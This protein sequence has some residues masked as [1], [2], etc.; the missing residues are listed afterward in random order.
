MIGSEWTKHKFGCSGE[1]RQSIILVP[2]KIPFIRKCVFLN[3]IIIFLQKVGGPW[4]LP[5]PP[6]ARALLIQ[7]FSHLHIHHFL[8]FASL[9]LL[10]CI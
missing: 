6:P 9:K 1:V 7:I 4:P 3:F 2:S 10:E 5:A 8:S